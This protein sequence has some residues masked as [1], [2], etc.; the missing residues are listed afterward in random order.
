MGGRGGSGPWLAAGAAALSL[1]AGAGHADSSLGAPRFTIEQVLSAPFPSSLTAASKGAGV[2]WVYDAQGVRNVWVTEGAGSH[3]RQITAF[4]GDDGM[5]MGELTFAPDGQTVLFSRGGSLEGGGPVNIMSDPSGAPPQ[6]IWA[7]SVGGGAPRKIAPGHTPL[8]SPRGDVVVFELGGQIWSAPLNGQG[9][10]SQLIHDRGRSSQ[11]AFSPDGA[12]LAFVS[13]RGDHSLIG[14]YDFAASTVRW[15]APSFDTDLAPAWSPSGDRLAF[16]RTPASPP[17]VFVAHRSDSP[18]SIW[19]ADASTG[20]GRAV[21]TAPEGPGSV[22][23]PVD[24]RM[25]TW[26]AGDRLVFPS[27][28]SGWEHLWSVS[29]HGGEARDLMPGAFEIFNVAFSADGSRLAFAANKDDIDHRHLFEVSVAGGPV[30]TLTS[31]AT[32]EDY[33]VFAGDGR[34]YGLHGDARNPMRPVAVGAHLTDLA[35][36][37]IPASFPVSR[38]VEPKQVVLP[39]TDGL[40]IHAQLFLPPKGVAGKGPALLFFHGGPIRQMVLGWNPMDAYTFMYAMNQYLASEGYVVLSVNY[41]GGTGYGMDFREAENFGPGGSSEFND[42]KA[43]ALWLRARPDVD[44]ARV[45]IWGG[46]YGGLMTALGLSRASDL[47]AAGVDYAGVHDWR[48]LLPYM[49]EPGA[50]PGPAELAWKSSA[51]ATIDQWRSPV[52]VIQADDDRNVPFAQSV[53]LVEALRKQGVPFEQLVIPDE[54]H[55]LL[56]HH[57]WLT[58]FHAQDDFFRRKL[59]KP[60]G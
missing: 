50:P 47:L 23:H 19:V 54:I 6:E 10:P 51:L 48:G 3:A 5:D 41:R 60:A 27:E 52:L 25:L 53:Q 40:P 1:L 17:K 11:V 45:G 34:I 16:V 15:M 7:A 49:V 39:S 30:R 56:R 37:A 36:G 31:G 58:M 20:V 44:P 35:P 59:G 55:D 18:W 42:I 46:S 33:P 57:S 21:F 4:T 43:S 2:A 32:I 29:A 8:V 13:S 28:R 24:E 22:F 12:R 38:L 9:Q 14:V 26:A